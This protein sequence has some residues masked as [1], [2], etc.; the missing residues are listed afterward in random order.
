[1]RGI[2]HRMSLRA[3][4]RA[5]ALLAS[6]A[7]ATPAARAAEPAAA[8]KATAEARPAGRAPASAGGK[9]PAKKAAGRAAAPIVWEPEPGSRGPERP[10]PVL[11]LGGDE[12]AEMVR[13]GRCGG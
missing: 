10:K 12:P 5:A 1:M 8:R 4:C 11:D 13:A 7:L 2:G 3:P 6:L 9:A